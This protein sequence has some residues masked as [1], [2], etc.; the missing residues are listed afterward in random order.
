MFHRGL[1]MLQGAGAVAAEQG[2][3]GQTVV[4]AAVARLPLQPL[5]ELVFGFG[6]PAESWICGE[7]GMEEGVEG[8]LP[9]DCGALPGAAV[10]LNAAED[11]LQHGWID[12]LEGFLF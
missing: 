3:T 7:S 12:R 8:L 10:G 9:D 11:L 1:Q 4:T 6:E 2:S 5:P